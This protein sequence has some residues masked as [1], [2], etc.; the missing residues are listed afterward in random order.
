ML[1]LNLP[2]PLANTKWA[3]ELNPIINNPLNNVL[4]LPNVVLT[5]GTNIIN[6]HLGHVQQGWFLVDKQGTAD[7]YRSAPFN[8][9]TLTLTS[10]SDVTV[11]LGVF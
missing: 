10:D 5:T 9:T 11:N 4:I 3:G 8:S 1:S 7:I 6:H 2:W